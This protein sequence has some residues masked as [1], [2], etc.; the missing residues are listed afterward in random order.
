MTIIDKY[1]EVKAKPRKVPETDAIFDNIKAKDM[2]YERRDF[3]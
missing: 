2:G 1:P 3:W